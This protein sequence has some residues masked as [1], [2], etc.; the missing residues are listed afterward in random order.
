MDPVKLSTRYAVENQTNKVY[1][2]ILALISG[3]ALLL[4]LAVSGSENKPNG[5]IYLVVLKEKRSGGALK[6]FCRRVM[7]V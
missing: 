5:K 1:R 2:Q 6:L 4:R 7:V 3:D